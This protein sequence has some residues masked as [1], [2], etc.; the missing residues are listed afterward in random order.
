MVGFDT[1]DHTLDIEV[2]PELSW[3]WRDEQELANHVTEGF[4]TA[5]VGERGPLRGRK[6]HR[7]HATA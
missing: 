7:S 2:T 5:S 1:Q 4:Y 3:R 6:S